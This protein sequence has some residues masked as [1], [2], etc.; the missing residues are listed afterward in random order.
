MT[1][2]RYFGMLNGIP[3]VVIAPKKLQTAVPL[4]MSYLAVSYFD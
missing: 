1:L 2:Q 3:D 4:A